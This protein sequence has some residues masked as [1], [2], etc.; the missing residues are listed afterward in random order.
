MI[1]MSKGVAPCAIPTLLQFY[2]I[3]PSLIYSL[4][5]PSCLLL[6]IG[7]DLRVHI[8][9]K[10]IEFFRLV[11]MSSTWLPCFVYL[12]LELRWI[13]NRLCNH[14]SLKGRNWVLMIN[15]HHR[16]YGT[17]GWVRQAW[18][19]VQY[20]RGG[21][22]VYHRRV[23]CRIQDLAVG[24]AHWFVYL[25]TTLSRLAIIATVSDGWWVML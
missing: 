19:I 20:S 3:S 6:I 2:I 13:F 21:S 25:S 9:Q 15:S 14:T 10:S 24:G 17:F 18:T 8:L 1:H 5:T 7:I 11:C 22:L 23:R 12:N 4:S 16:A